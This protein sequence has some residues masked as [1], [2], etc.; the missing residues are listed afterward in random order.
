MTL[1]EGLYY[2]NNIG[3]TSG[4]SVGGRKGR[5]RREYYTYKTISWKIIITLNNY[6]LKRTNMIVDNDARFI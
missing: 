3:G 1:A 2:C 5:W 6:I 4:G